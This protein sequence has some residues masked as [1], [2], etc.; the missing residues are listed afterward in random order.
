[1]SRGGTNNIH[2][3]IWGLHSGNYEIILTMG[4]GLPETSVRFTRLHITSKTTDV[5]C[6]MH[7]RRQDEDTVRPN[8]LSDS[9]QH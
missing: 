2:A 9:I 1:M 4:T 6:K 3:I 7:V 8:F 5:G